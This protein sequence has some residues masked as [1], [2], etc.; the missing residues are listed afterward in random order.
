L[1]LDIRVVIIDIRSMRAC[2]SL[3][4]SFEADY[5]RFDDFDLKSKKIIFQRQQSLVE[6]F[7]KCGFSGYTNLIM[8]GY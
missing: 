3:K 5:S 4:V 8:S 1:I 6:I 7:L 2:S